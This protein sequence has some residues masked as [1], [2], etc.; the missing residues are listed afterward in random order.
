LMWFIRWCGRI[1]GH[2]TEWT[3]SMYFNS[4]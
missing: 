2:T 3:T 1:C 4:F